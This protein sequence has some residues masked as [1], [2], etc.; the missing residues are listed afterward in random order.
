MA[1]V[2]ILGFSSAY[3]ER[4]G[5]F[6]RTHSITGSDY[7]NLIEDST[8]ATFIWKRE[9]S[10]WILV[11]GAMDFPRLA[12]RLK[13]S[14]EQD[15]ITS[16][17]D[18]VPGRKGQSFP[19]DFEY[20]ERKGTIILHA[21]QLASNAIRAQINGK[22][23]SSSRSNGEL[24]QGNA[25]KSI[26]TESSIPEEDLG[27]ALA[28]TPMSP[29]TEV[30]ASLWS[31][32]LSSGFGIPTIL[33]AGKYC[34][35]I[36][37][38][39][40]KASPPIG[41]QFRQPKI[42]PNFAYSLALLSLGA[43]SS[44]ICTFFILRR[45][46]LFRI[47]K[48]NLKFKGRSNQ[49]VGR[50]IDEKVP[51]SQL[52]NP[53]ST[54][55]LSEKAVGV[56]SEPILDQRL[57]FKLQDQN[58]T[59]LRLQTTLQDASLRRGILETKVQ[60]LNSK[61]RGLALKLRRTRQTLT[62]VTVEHQ[63]VLLKEQ[64]EKERIQKELLLWKDANYKELKSLLNECGNTLGKELA[65]IEV[66]FHSLG[67]SQ[68]PYLLTE[69]AKY[70]FPELLIRALAKTVE[71]IESESIRQAKMDVSLSQALG[72]YRDLESRI[73]ATARLHK[74]SMAVTSS[75]VSGKNGR[76]AFA[77]SGLIQTSLAFLAVTA[78]NP[79]VKLQRSAMISNIRRC[80]DI[81]ETFNQGVPMR[82]LRTELNTWPN[83]GDTYEATNND[84]NRMGYQQLLDEVES[85][86]GDRISPYY[87]I[88]SEGA[89]SK[90][91]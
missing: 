58:R 86:F 67:L 61:R 7:V 75:I 45:K 14:S 29:D 17:W 91:V 54:S 89:L 85:Q 72:K 4:I 5:R 77:M 47:L 65:Q 15:A 50:Q 6:G 16:V 27:K 84:F 62:S 25:L 19:N 81:I 2:L 48:W 13:W 69:L 56:T 73:L 88:N 31:I 66:D 55:N 41:Q 79:Q 43:L 1:L 11:K 37:C 3:G 38:V 63:S 30:Y 33:P 68:E 64:R 57:E 71:R 9:G 12:S 53:T 39:I 70:N 83:D 90:V 22:E 34:L 42:S 8:C 59:I 49:E 20:M 78:A 52:F 28:A 23:I 80:A 18:F 76:G 82:N 51:S 87:L 10:K 26:S 40:D 60:S 21:T 35:A 74:A 36:E 32:G 24:D 44:S 46:T